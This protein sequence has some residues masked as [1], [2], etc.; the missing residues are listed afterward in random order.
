MTVTLIPDDKYAG[1]WRVRTHDGLSGPLNRTR[2]ADLAASL[3]SRAVATARQ[4]VGSALKRS[5]QPRVRPPS[6]KRISGV[7][8]GGRL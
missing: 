6:N 2:A 3:T 1:M 7:L 5:A 4:N 8:T